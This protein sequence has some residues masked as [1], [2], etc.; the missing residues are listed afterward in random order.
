MSTHSD[1]GCCGC[2]CGCGPAFI[3]T[4]TLIVLKLMDMTHLEWPYIFAPLVA[5]P[6]LFFV[7]NLLGTAALT[8]GSSAAARY[9]NDRST[10]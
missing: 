5:I 1:D 10:P 9:S 6:A 2:G 4:A 8:V 7:A 3:V